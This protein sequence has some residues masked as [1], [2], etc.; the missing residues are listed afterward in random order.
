MFARKGS[1]VGESSVPAAVPR[2]ERHRHAFQ[3]ANDKRIRRLPKRRLDGNFPYILQLRHLVQPTAA[4]NSDIY[5]FHLLMFE[6]PAQE[7]D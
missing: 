4:D 6:F 3:F 5:L 1:S 2:Q 7:V